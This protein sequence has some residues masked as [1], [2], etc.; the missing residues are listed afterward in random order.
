MGP[1][2]HARHEILILQANRGFQADADCLFSFFLHFTDRGLLILI[3]LRH[4]FCETQTTADLRLLVREVPDQAVD[5][6]LLSVYQN[7]LR[8]IFPFRPLKILHGKIRQLFPEFPDHFLLRIRK[9][10]RK[11]LNDIFFIAKPGLHGLAHGF[12][13]PPVNGFSRP[14]KIS[15]RLVTAHLVRQ[16]HRQAFQFLTGKISHLHA[17][18]LPHSVILSTRSARK[19]GSSF[20]KLFMVTQG[21]FV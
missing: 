4:L 14:F 3:L 9:F 6:V 19:S 16:L 5:V 17:N 11:L 12:L 21:V 13:Q 8:H 18:T 10:L 1:D 20:L 7:P 15:G 2:F